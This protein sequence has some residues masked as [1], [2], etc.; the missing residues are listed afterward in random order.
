MN[1]L[2]YECFMSWDIVFPFQSEKMHERISPFHTLRK[3]WA[4]LLDNTK[5]L[6]YRAQILRKVRK[7]DELLILLMNFKPDESLMYFCNH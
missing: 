7:G 3:I 5:R 4:L 6:L 2:L 1:K